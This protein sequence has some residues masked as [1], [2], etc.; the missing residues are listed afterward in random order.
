MKYWRFAARGEK[1]GR[2]GFIRFFPLLLAVKVILLPTPVNNINVVRLHE[3]SVVEA[4][5]F[6]LPE[7]RVAIIDSRRLLQLLSDFGP[8]CT[9]MP[10][11][12]L[13][14]QLVVISSIFRQPLLKLIPDYATERW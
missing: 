1:K 12:S 5:V 10:R 14:A 7:Q 4:S 3:D 9:S 13:F 6:C 11:L 8:K 2:S